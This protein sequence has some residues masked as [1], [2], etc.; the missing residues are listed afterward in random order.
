[1]EFE[2]YKMFTRIENSGETKEIGIARSK[3][4]PNC[5][6]VLSRDVIKYGPKKDE[7][8]VCTGNEIF[9]G[10]EKA[11]WNYLYSNYGPFSH[12]TL[13]RFYTGPNVKSITNQFHCHGLIQIGSTIKTK[14]GI[15]QRYFLA[16]SYGENTS[17][18]LFLLM[19]NYDIND[20][21]IQKI[22]KIFNLDNLE[23]GGNKNKVVAKVIKIGSAKACTKAFEN[24]YRY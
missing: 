7:E 6:C 9:V 10:S 17:W 3:T 1:M 22:E 12:L 11:C 4:V 8:F 16:K 19:S 13:D 14:D 5:K 15:W 2:N 18:M 23:E 24:L 21:K 20:I